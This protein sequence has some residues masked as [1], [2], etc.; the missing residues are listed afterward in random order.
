MKRIYLTAGLACLAAAASGAEPLSKE[1]LVDAFDKGRSLLVVTI[2]SVRAEGKMYFYRA[3]C[4][5][6]VL[7]GD[8]SSSDLAE[9]MDLFAG[10]SYGSTLEAGTDYAL[11]VTKD[12]PCFMSWAHRD[13]WLKL[14]KGNPEARRRLLTHSRS[15]Y[16]QSTI[17][18]FREAKTPGTAIV[19]RL[20]PDV[21]AACKEFRKQR[22]GRQ[23][24]ARRIGESAVGSRR[25]ESTPWSSE[26]VWLP[27]V[28]RLSRFEA[29]AL[30]GKPTLKLGYT[31]KWYCGKY[32]NAST[33]QAG[34]LT[35]T[36]DADEKVTD[37][38]YAGEPRS[39][40]VR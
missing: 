12:A 18:R 15:A 30:F 36:F 2:L 26:R 40:W 28:V 11:F 9:P 13:A 39:H 17:R 29:V 19:P 4:V 23:A 31:Y 33:N 32:D 1:V 20:E 5:E 14:D 38:L 10:A 34:V 6:P 27:P 25:D 21:L 7:R 22:D 37:L 16:Q 35:A 8:L 3:K 24:Q